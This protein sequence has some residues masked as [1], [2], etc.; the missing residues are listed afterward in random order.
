L[1]P[2]ILFG[3]VAINLALIAYTVGIIAAHRRRRATTLVLG[4]F[5]VAVALDVVATGCMVAGSS[6]SWFTPHGVVGYTALLVMVVVVSRLWALSRK[7]PDA[8]ISAKLY[9]FLRG[10]YVLW[11]VAY[12]VGVA[13]AASR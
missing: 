2:V 9:G 13:L 10:A 12:G 11:L 4:G 3:V 8:E 1:S 7:G 5:A 6:K